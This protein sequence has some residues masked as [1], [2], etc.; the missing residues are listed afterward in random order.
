MKYHCGLLDERPEES[1]PLQWVKRPHWGNRPPE[2]EHELAVWLAMPGFS[3]TYHTHTFGLDRTRIARL[4]LG[5]P[6]LR[7]NVIE[8]WLSAIR[9]DCVKLALLRPNGVGDVPVISQMRA[10]ADLKHKRI[11]EVARDYGVTRQTIHDWRTRGFRFGRQPV[12][13]GFELLVA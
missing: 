11:S 10:V 6:M 9:E 8:N 5:D 12:P 4:M 7:G 13:S 3:V 1:R 2:I